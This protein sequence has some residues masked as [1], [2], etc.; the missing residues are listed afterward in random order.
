MRSRVEADKGALLRLWIRNG[1]VGG[2]WA[3]RVGSVWVEMAYFPNGTAAMRYEEEWCDKCAH[4]PHNEPD[5]L[6]GCPVLDLHWLWNY[7]QFGDSGDAKQ[8]K[9]ILELFIPEEDANGVKYAAKCNMFVEAPK[10]DPSTQLD[11]GL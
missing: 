4:C 7:D 11:L 10:E 9:H 3:A 1:A 2:G 6:K 8:K 5:P